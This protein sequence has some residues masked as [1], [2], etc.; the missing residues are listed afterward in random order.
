MKIFLVALLFALCPLLRAYDVN[1]AGRS[2]HEPLCPMGCLVKSVLFEEWLRQTWPK[3]TAIIIPLDFTVRAREIRHSVCL[4]QHEGAW[5]IYDSTEGLYVLPPEG[6]PR[7]PEE[8]TPDH[9]QYAVQ[10][11]VWNKWREKAPHDTYG[12]V[13][14]LRQTASR[15]RPAD[16][17]SY[18][19][20]YM[21]RPALTFCYDDKFFV[22]LWGQGTRLLEDPESS[23]YSGASTKP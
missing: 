21:G 7:T 14:D 11:T 23:L 19:P 2:F 6:Y 1:V 5:L 17:A 3:D 13:D 4:F 22:Y 8:I 10:I 16:R 9:M 15:F 20:D 12:G 18:K